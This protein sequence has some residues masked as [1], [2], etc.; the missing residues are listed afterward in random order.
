[1]TLFCPQAWNNP[2]SPEDF[3]SNACQSKYTV[4]SVE[5]SLPVI[6]G[7]WSL[8]T[9]NCAMWLNGFNDNL[10]GFPKVP[11]DY[12]KC[13]Q[14]YLGDTFTGLPLDRSRPI[15]GPYGTGTSGPSFGYCPT[16]CTE[17]FDEDD[18]IVTRNLAHKK[19]SSFNIGH[20][21]YFWNFKTEIDPKWDFM[22]SVERGWIPSN[23]A[24]L[25]QV[26]DACASEDSGDFICRAKRNAPVATLKGS[27]DWV[28]K[29]SNIDCTGM[30]EKYPTLFDQCDHFFNEYWHDARTSGATCDFGGAGQLGSPEK[31]TPNADSPI[32]YDPPAYSRR[33]KKHSSS[34]SSSS[35]IGEEAIDKKQRDADGES[36]K[37]AEK[38]TADNDDTDTLKNP[39]TT[40]SSS[41]VDAAT[42]TEGT[43]LSL[44]VMWVC[45]LI[46]CSMVSVYATNRF[47]RYGAYTQLP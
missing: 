2:G 16:S 24:Q 40:I 35:S 15:Q 10:P 14:S 23:V 18:D 47:H 6:V 37:E 12:V 34:S 45:S 36:K 7:E 9:D 46:M 11:C 33:Q 20:G 30:E 39:S 25:S 5:Q 43:S 13:P 17:F 28:C 44:P 3:Y 22:R 1:V 26:S 8:A 19:L 21:W 38:P 29:Q 41:S 32:S 4:S 31:K 27:L 42:A